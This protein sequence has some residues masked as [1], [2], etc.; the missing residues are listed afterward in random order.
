MFFNNKIEQDYF[1]WLYNVVN[2]DK[3][4]RNISYKKLFHA[5]HSVQFEYSIDMDS[6]RY[7]DGEALRYR[8]GRLK[9]YPD[10]AIASYLDI[11]PCSVLEMM[12]ALS[13][14]CEEHIMEDSEIGDR[15][16]QWFWNM[17]I[18]LGLGGMTDSKFNE[19]VF[20]VIIRRF[21]DRDYEPNGKG[22]LFTIKDTKQ[23]MRNVEIWY[24]MCFYLDS[25]M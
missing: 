3:Y 4:S 11:K 16:G 1:N 2:A 17:I 5:L 23:D 15:T 7:Y 21:L 6:N 14:R 18:S 24:Q 22:G 19:R 20:T 25:I 8:F 13:I 9:D 12:I 10:S